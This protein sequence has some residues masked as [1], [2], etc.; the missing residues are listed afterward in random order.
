MKK[1]IIENLLWLVGV[2]AYNFLFWKEE[3][4]LNTLLFTVLMIGSLFYLHPESRY[5]TIARLTALCTLFTAVM[6]VVFNSEFSKIVYVLSMMTMV[7]FVQQRELK[8]LWYGLLLALTSFFS[9]PLKAADRFRSLDF[10]QKNTLHSIWKFIRLAILPL[11][12]VGIFFIFY[13]FSNSN[14]AEL[15]SHFFIKIAK[16]M[17]QLNWEMNPQ[18]IF[19]FIGSVFVVGGIL[20]TTKS[21][22]LLDFQVQHKETIERI[23]K[24]KRNF[25]DNPYSPIALK[26]E[27]RTGLMMLLSLNALTL[28]VN[29][30]DIQN[31]WIGF[32]KLNAHSIAFDVHFGT[33]VLIFTI[34]MA[35]GVLLFYFR[36]NLNFYKNNRLLKISALTWIVQNMILVLSVAL[37][38]IKYVDY[39]GLTYKRLGIF[40]FL[41]L[42]LYGL[43]T[44]L[45]KVRE[46]KTAY[47]LFQHNAWSLYIV[48][49]LLTSVNWDVA[50]TRYNLTLHDTGQVD[51][52]YLIDDLSSKNL[53][54]LYKNIDL[55][56]G[57]TTLDYANESLVVNKKKIFLY[58]QKN[59]SWRS[60]NFAD[61][62][63]LLYL[64]EH[65]LTD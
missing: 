7:G 40:I 28:L 34:F 11:F 59:L 56:S 27:Y 4:G 49:V 53:S 54:L 36:G 15:S 35:I 21:T 57:R 25:L 39:Y 17:K 30:T 64:Q 12:V 13:L 42:V 51:Y 63:T 62:Q 22:W 65:S 44:M 8:F 10:K 26:N 29:L 61:H 58:Q 37:R 33:Y 47:Y 6:I 31:T 50:I 60:W 38:N 3:M 20:W 43:F 45:Y 46:R 16:W 52:D 24:V 1:S 41:I 14:F 2:L 18:R 48:L 9:V 23:R 32:A 19:Y 55:F 5:A